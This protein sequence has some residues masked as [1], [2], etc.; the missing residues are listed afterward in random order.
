MARAVV[1]LFLAAQTFQ[2]TPY[3]ACLKRETARL[4]RSGERPR[5]VAGAA[6]D[7]CHK[8]EPDW[9]PAMAGA[10]HDVLM[11]KLADQVVEIRAARH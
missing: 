2:Q 8:L 5:D 11:E 9:T 3:W 10:M 4:E 7:V 1:L 6:L